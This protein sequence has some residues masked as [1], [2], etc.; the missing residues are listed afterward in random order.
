MTL[1]Q[2]IR[3]NRLRTTELLVV[4]A[5]LIGALAGALDAVYGLGPAIA[6]AAVGLA[7]ALFSWF[8]SASVVAATAGARPVTK[9]EQPELYRIVENLS[10]AAGLPATPQVRM[11]DDPAPNAFAAGRDPKHCFVAVTTGLVQTMDHRELE[12]VIGHEIAHVQHRDVRLMTLVAVLVGVVA[13]ISDLALRMLFFGGGRRRGGGNA[14]AIVLAIAIVGLVLAPIAAVLIQMAISRRREFLADAG[15]AEITGD[16]EGLARA[17]RK[18]ADDPREIR[19]TS[20]S[21]A[22]LYIEGPLGKASGPRAALANLFTTHPPLEARI[23]ALE[24][25]GG[26]KLP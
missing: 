21:T 8:F 19:D 6:V 16:A 25:I 9:A 14:N 24:Q 2:Q 23:A 3:M 5:L 1:R 13:M 17:L 22:H 26:F 4:F 18:L 12:G 15:G 11:V 10:I 7:W 20:R